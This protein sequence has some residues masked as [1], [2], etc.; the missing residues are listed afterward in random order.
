MGLMKSALNFLGLNNKDGGA[1]TANL[2]GSLDEFLSE[3]VQRMGYDIRFSGQETS[4]GIRY[5]IEGEELEDFLGNSCE[6]LEALAHLSMRYARRV[7]A[8][9][10]ITPEP[11]TNEDGT[12]EEGDFRG[13][14]IYFECG[15]FR[16]RKVDDIRTMAG[17]KRQRV[18]DG[19]RPVYISAMGPA[20]RKVIHTFLAETGEVVSESIGSGYFKRIRLRLKDSPAHSEGGG[21]RRG[22][23]GG[24]GGRGRGR[25]N[26]QGGGN[27]R[28][29]RPG[30]GGGFNNDRRPGG[31]GGGNRGP[32][33]RKPGGREFEDTFLNFQEEA[34]GNV[35]VK[36]HVENE[37]DDN[38]GNR[39][40]PNDEPRFGYRANNNGDKN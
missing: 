21:Q 19:G 20:D 36:E 29:R 24:G 5:D 2:P 32:A 10:G 14:R 15:D 6:M 27:G 12:P 17:E 34:N 26:F 3:I 33:P 35:A 40:G 38:I 25:G 28:G 13:P 1:S 18:M 11:R 31:G 4:E 8:A 39:A 16:Q 23:G 30:G 37:I 22:N 7:Q 9:S